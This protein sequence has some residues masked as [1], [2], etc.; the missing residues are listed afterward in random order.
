MTVFAP[1]SEAEAADIIRQAQAARTPLALAGSGTKA[2]IGQSGGA[3]HCLTSLGLQGITLYEPSEMVIS[4]RA[5]TR[6]S[7][8][9]RVLAARGQRLTFEPPEPAL[10]TGAGGEQTI[11]GIVAANWSGPR[12]IAAGACRDSLIGVRFVNG[13]GESVKSGG[14]VMKNVTG[15]DFVK[16]LAGSWG[17][18]G[19]LLEV[20]FKVL[21]APEAEITLALSDL[22]DRRGVEALCVAMGSPWGVSGAAHLPR[23]WRDGGGKQPALTLLRLEGSAFSVRHRAQALGGRL[24][25]FG[26][27]SLIEEDDS[28]LVWSRVRDAAPVAEPGEWAVWRIST[29]PSR[30]PDVVAAVKAAREALHFYDW[31]GGLVWLSTPAGGD[32]GESVV[33]AAVAQAGGHATLVRAPVEV[34]AS[35]PVFQPQAAALARIGRDLKRAFDPAG[36]LEPGRMVAGV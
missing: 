10:L 24:A 16:L 5:G 28:R 9:A 22:D 7:E 29:A 36:V 2:G 30:G 35:V 15:L 33:R 3:A 13:R 11:G 6:L 21:P 19:F 34:R 26:G 25:G 32:A 17:T 18:L 20:T 27:H 12:R 4:A 31:S 8:V 23:D 1:A 14:R